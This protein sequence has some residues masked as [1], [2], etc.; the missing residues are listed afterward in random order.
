MSQKSEAEK[1]VKDTRR[2]TRKKYSGSFHKWTL[3]GDSSP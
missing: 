1:R 2:N 3:L